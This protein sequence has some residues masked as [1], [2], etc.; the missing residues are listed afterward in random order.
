MKINLPDFKTMS[1]ND[2]AFVQDYATNGAVFTPAIAGAVIY[3][4]ANDK[5]KAAKQIIWGLIPFMLL[6]GIVGA[7]YG[8]KQLEE[9]NKAV[10]TK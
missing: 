10:S 6:G 3:L 8:N 7:Y 5:A 1:A 2:K 9:L 4:I